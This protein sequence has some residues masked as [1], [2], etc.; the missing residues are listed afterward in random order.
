VNYRGDLIFA[1]LKVVVG[2]A[3]LVLVAQW[4]AIDARKTKQ[5]LQ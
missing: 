3:L 4:R 2:V 1:P 5:R